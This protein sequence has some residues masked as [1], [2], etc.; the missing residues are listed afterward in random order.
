MASLV[1]C[2]YF[3]CEYRPLFIAVVS[4]QDEFVCKVDGALLQT[5]EESRLCD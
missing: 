2:T 1:A 3:L 5:K 4:G